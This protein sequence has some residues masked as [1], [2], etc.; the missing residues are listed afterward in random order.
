MLADIADFIGVSTVLQAEFHP[1]DGP[2]G[3]PQPRL[4][5]PVPAA[6][7]AGHGVELGG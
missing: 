6:N 5:Y 4:D 2:F 1:T 7:P 3:P